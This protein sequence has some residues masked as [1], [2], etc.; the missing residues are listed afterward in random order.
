[1]VNQNLSCANTTDRMSASNMEAKLIYP[2]NLLTEPERGLMGQEYV[3]TGQHYWNSSP[4]DFAFG[5]TARVH[6]AYSSG[7]SA[8]SFALYAYG[9]RPVISLRSDSLV[10]EGDGGY[11]TPYV[12]GPLVTR[13]NVNYNY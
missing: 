1:M 8:N 5:G 3:V 11:T 4:Y 10:T 12:V 2:I 13:D 9:A 6:F 7:T